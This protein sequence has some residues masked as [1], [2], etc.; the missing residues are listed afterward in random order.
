M[1]APLNGGQVA[2]ERNADENFTDVAHSAARR[3]RV[4]VT[5]A[6]AGLSQKG[7]AVLRDAVWH[8]QC[9]AVGARSRTITHRSQAG[10]RDEVEKTKCEA[11]G[12]SASDA[13]RFD[14]P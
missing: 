5:P 14:K 1:P 10:C 7:Q 3:R 4:E 13:A 11:P 6:S 8:H 12:H 9:D 2:A